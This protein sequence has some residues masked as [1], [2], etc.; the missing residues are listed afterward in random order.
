MPL[1]SLT[2][3]Q[4]NEALAKAAETRKERAELKAQLKHGKHSLSEVLKH[5]EDDVVGRMKV[6]AV[7]Q[8][9]PGIG[10]IRAQQIMERL[11]IPETRRLRGLGSKQTEALLAELSAP[12]EPPLTP[13]G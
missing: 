12:D 4:R 7:L 9:L 8:S 11:S 10:K 1:P 2:P 5:T 3:E 6:D 13:S